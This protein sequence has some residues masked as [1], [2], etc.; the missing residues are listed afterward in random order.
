MYLFR[1][2]F[3]QLTGA[4]ATLGAFP[5]LAQAA[6][7]PSRQVRVIVGLP[8][9][10][11]PDIAARLVAPLLSQRLGQPVVVENRPGAAGNIGAEYVVRSV[12]DGYTLLAAISGNAINASIYPNLP[13]NFIRDLAPVALFGFTPYV[14]VASP[15]VP[16]KTLPEFIAYA[17]AN[18]GKV[19]MASPGTG[20]APH[21]AGELFKMMAGLDMVHVPYRANYLSDLIGGQV[22]VAFIALGPVRGYI[23]GG[24][25]RALGVTSMKRLEVLPDAPAIVESVPGY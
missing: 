10:L 22:Q 17:K 23:Q 8:A 1:R 4:A 3:L 7:Y 12:P 16:A 5:R 9:G 6:D 14:M 20:T 18:S 21:L 2:K 24:Q 13:F 19:N 15:S 25:L 11:A